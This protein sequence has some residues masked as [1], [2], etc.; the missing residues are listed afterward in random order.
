M[1]KLCIVSTE[2]PSGHHV[3]LLS[4]VPAGDI[5]HMRGKVISGVPSEVDIVNFCTLL[6]LI[7]VEILRFWR[8]ASRDCWIS[9]LCLRTK[10]EFWQLW[11]LSILTDVR[12]WEHLINQIRKRKPM[13]HFNVC[14][15]EADPFLKV[16]QETQTP[17]WKSEDLEH[18]EGT[19]C[20]APVWRSRIYCFPSDF[21]YFKIRSPPWPKTLQVWWNRLGI[22]WLA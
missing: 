16:S 13:T 11:P 10:V 15:P 9:H 1:A 21:Y 5:E 2:N 22:G 14:K 17:S 8:W 19:E 6:L 18:L 12:R 4:S 3:L 20:R 7:L